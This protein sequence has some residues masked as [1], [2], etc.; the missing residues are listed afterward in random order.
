VVFVNTT[1]SQELV[2]VD[3]NQ[4]E[5][6]V[7][8]ILDAKSV[9]C[10]EISINFV[11]EKEISELHEEFFDDPTPTDC[12]TFPIDDIDDVSNYKILGEIFVCPQVALS[13][14]QEHLVDFEEELTLYVVHG[15][16]HLLG[17]DDIEEEE[18]KVM[19]EQEA[20]CMKLLKEN[21]LILRV[22]KHQPI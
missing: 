6:L 4:L 18:R 10:D 19:R 16:L 21:Q 2:K 14:S 11:T 9:S 15:I 3:A 20:F 8:C 13:Y 7:A 17:F 22:K 12:I 1:S 5:A